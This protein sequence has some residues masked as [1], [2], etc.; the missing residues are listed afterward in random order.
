M[1]RKITT[2][3]GD[4]S[5]LTEG[6]GMFYECH[7]LTSF[8]SELSSL[9][10]GNNMFSNCSNLKTFNSDLSSL[11]NGYYMFANCF[12][13]TD[14]SSDLSSL[15]IG[16]R[17]FDNCSALTTFASDLSSLDNGVGMFSSCS[18]LT[19][20]YSN[21]NSLTDGESM[22]SDCKLDT[23]SVKN[24]AETIKTVTYKS[25]IDIGIGNTTPNVEETEAFNTIASKRWIVYV[26]GSSYAPT[27]T[28]AIMTLDEL[29]EEITTPIP[30]WAKP[31]QSDEEHAKY[32]DSEGNFFN[33][34]GGQFIYGDDISTYG[35]FI[36]EED[37]AANMR[38]TPYVKS[39]AETSNE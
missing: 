9:T 5:S 37:A 6:E 24:I 35:M 14:F 36:N 10:S 30:F 7:N 4:L 21:L 29:G 18:N 38:L 12:N 25:I 8:T 19:T 13:L 31:V 39:Q 33:I 20:F 34:L 28:A 23:A 15:T 17:M 1:N 22:F 26:N 27:S 16:C 2:F 11:S 32:V 3:I